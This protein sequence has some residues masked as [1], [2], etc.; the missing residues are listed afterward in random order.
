MVNKGSYIV[1]EGGTSTLIDEVSRLLWVLFG[2]T[3]T[4]EGIKEDFVDFTV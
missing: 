3:D 2:T 4:W 1:I